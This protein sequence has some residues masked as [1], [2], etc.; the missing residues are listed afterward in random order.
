MRLFIKDIRCASLIALCCAVLSGCGSVRGQGPDRPANANSTLTQNPNVVPPDAKEGGIEQWKSCAQGL[1]P[2][3]GYAAF[4]IRTMFEPPQNV[5]QLLHNLKIAADRGLLLQ[6]SFF[7]E[8]LLLQFFNGSTVTW[9]GP[10]RYYPD[11]HPTGHFNVSIAS[12]AFPKLEIT[13]EANCNVLKTN[14]AMRSTIDHEA[15]GFLEIAVGSDAGITLSDVR[16]L[17]GPEDQL[18]SDHQGHPDE[19]IQKSSIKGIATYQNERRAALEHSRVHTVFY[20]KRNGTN[21]FGGRDMVAKIEIQDHQYHI[22]E[23]R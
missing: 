7:E 9:T 19:L 17:F 3:G 4:E 15:N 8:S 21:S 20:F 11:T 1:H 16:S 18:Y 23:D 5:P 13:L 12:D 10:G 14:V 6:P 2:G 22:L